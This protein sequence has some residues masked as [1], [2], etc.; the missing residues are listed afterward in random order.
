MAKSVNM[1]E[2]E[3]RDDRDEEAAV[4]KDV[5]GIKFSTCV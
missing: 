2:P 4:V 3:M 1:L 5:G